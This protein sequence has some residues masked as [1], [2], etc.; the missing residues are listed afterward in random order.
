MHLLSFV[1]VFTVVAIVINLVI[2]MVGASRFSV[3]KNQ[4]QEAAHWS[5]GWFYQSESTWLKH[6]VLL[7]ESWFL[8]TV[9]K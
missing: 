7:D 2:G 5:N 1:N 4:S 6:A 3:P 8:R 9:I